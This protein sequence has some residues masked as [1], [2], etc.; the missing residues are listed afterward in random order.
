MRR[1]NDG[2]YEKIKDI[3][4]Y[5]DININSDDETFSGEE[6][7]EIEKV[8]SRKAK[9]KGLDFYDYDKEETDYDDDYDD[10]ESPDEEEE[11]EEEKEEKKE[12]EKEKSSEEKRREQQRLREREET[13]RE[14]MMSAAYWFNEMHKRGAKNISSDEKRYLELIIIEL[15]DFYFPNLE[16]L[17]PDKDK[18]A[19]EKIRESIEEFKSGGGN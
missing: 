9:E 10:I 19:I 8:K 5:A 11:E 12:K 15:A 4:K 14:S 18:E 6:E 1:K 2:L 17:K 16:A 3:A 7:M 13:R